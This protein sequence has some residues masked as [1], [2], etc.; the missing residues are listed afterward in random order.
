MHAAKVRPSAVFE[1]NETLGQ[2][3]AG[4]SVDW[5]ALKTSRLLAMQRDGAQLKDRRNSQKADAKRSTI[6]PA[7]YQ[8]LLANRD[9]R[10][11][12]SET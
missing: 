9:E 12:A 10:G 7:S 1:S 11:R 4:N 5:W 6:A 8:W 2:V 3:R